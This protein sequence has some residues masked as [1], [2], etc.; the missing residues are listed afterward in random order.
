MSKTG[1]NS[2]FREGFCP[3]PTGAGKF[4]VAAVSLSVREHMAN[5]T[6]A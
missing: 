3:R 6:P 5:V 1:K 2:S 4:A